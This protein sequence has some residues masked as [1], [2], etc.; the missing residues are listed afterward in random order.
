MDTELEQY[1]EDAATEEVESEEIPA[2]GK[3]AEGVKEQQAGEQHGQEDGAKEEQEEDDG[4]QQAIPRGRFNQVY[5][6]LRDE[7]T[8]NDELLAENKRLRGED[9]KPEGQ[10]PVDI[11]ALEREYMRAMFEDSEEKALEL[12]FKINEELERRA[13]ERAT[14]L[15]TEQI[16]A[17]ETQR[18]ADSAADEVVRAH[19]ELNKDEKLLAELIEWRDFYIAGKN[20]PPHNAIRTAAARMFPTKIEPGDATDERKAATVQRNIRENAQQPPAVR[21]ATSERSIKTGLPETQEGYE[22][23]KDEERIELLK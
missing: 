19:P 16:S 15:V 22:S 12:R 8:R 10:K 5:K 4:Y 9:V 13:E 1:F 18:L 23:L 17:R 20:M 3:E 7:Q 11:A 14:R 6:Q 2:Q 21:G